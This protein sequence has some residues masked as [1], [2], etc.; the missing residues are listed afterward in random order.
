[1]KYFS[2]TSLS[3]HEYPQQYMMVL[4]FPWTP[5]TSSASMMPTHTMDQSVQFS[6]MMISPI[7]SYFGGMGE[8]VLNPNFWRGDLRFHNTLHTC[9]WQTN[10]RATVQ[11]DLP[12]V[13]MGLVPAVHVRIQ[14]LTQE[15][16]SVHESW[17]LDA[18]Q[19]IVLYYSRQ[20]KYV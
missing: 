9:G 19:A 20:I 13:W 10:D 11:L 7:S 14:C 16:K 17:C 6:R 1:M 18:V 8:G 5:L 2:R 4:K 3:S 15:S 12:W